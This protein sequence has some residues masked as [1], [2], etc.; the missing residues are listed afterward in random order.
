MGKIKPIWE[1]NKRG[2][3]GLIKLNNTPW[4]NINDTVCVLYNKAKS[5]FNIFN[6]AY[7]ENWTNII[8]LIDVDN[9]GR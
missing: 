5:Y 8:N 4:L 2:G 3:R 6:N 7:G 1:K 9:G